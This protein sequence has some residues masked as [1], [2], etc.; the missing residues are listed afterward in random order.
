MGQHIEAGQHTYASVNW[1][2]TASDNA[3]LCKVITWTYADLL[4]N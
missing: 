4:L 2:L 1:V 3:L